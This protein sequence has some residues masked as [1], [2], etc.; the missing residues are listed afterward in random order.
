MSLG[1]E[2]EEKRVAE[3]QRKGDGDIKRESFSSA[4]SFP[5][6]SHSSWY[7]LG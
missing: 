2:A 6:W 5:K 1:T 7:W 3:G 4:G